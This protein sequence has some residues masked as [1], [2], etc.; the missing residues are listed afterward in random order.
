MPAILFIKTSSLGDVIHH[1]PA[2]VDARR[3]LPDARIDWVVEEEFAPLV[4]LHAAVNDVIPVATRRWRWALFSPSSWS[5]ASRFRWRVR[6]G[7]YD[8]VIDTQGLIRTG[9]IA[10]NARA[11]R[12]GYDRNSIKEPLA[13][14]FYDIRHAVPRDLHAIE[15]NRRLTGLALGYSPDAPI[16]YGLDRMALRTPAARPYAVLVHASARAEKR[17]P[18]ARWIEVA[19]AL[20]ARGLDAVLPWG[21]DQERSIAER[22]SAAAPRA[23]VAARTPLDQVARLIAGASLVVGVDTGILHLAAALGVPLVAIFTA[24]E[25]GLTGPMGKGPI[26]IVGR[27]GQPPTAAQ[28]IAAIERVTRA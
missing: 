21:S 26:E 25:P 16:D 27:K 2:I 19:A 12:H 9:L 5:E 24:S 17:W 28:V 22:I 4:K 18:E 8:M 23:R 11:T 3:H 1:M 13:A 6:D 10:R 20:A 15:R 7:R 14:L